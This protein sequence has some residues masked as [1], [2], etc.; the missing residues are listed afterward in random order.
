M[1]SGDG[2]Y[3]YHRSW[4]DEPALPFSAIRGYIDALADGRDIERPTEQLAAER[5]RLAEEYGSLLDAEARATFDELLGL[6]RLVFPYVEEHKFY[7]EYW[8][9]S[10]FFNK[11]REFGGLLADHGFLADSEDVFQLSRH[12]VAEALEELCLT[13]AHG[14]PATLDDRRPVGR[15]RVRRSTT[16]SR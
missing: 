9:Q 4:F 16:R 14:G 6:S 3:H 11:V 15:C 1:G 10:R 7:C 8:F 2:F 13:W 5:E 12:E